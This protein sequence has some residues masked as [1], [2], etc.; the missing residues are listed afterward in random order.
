MSQY[1]SPY[2]P[3]SFVPTAGDAVGPQDPLAG[4]RRAATL[5][6]VVGGLIFLLGSCNTIT[7]FVVSP[8]EIIERQRAMMHGNVGQFQ[9][10]GET[11]R[12]ITII[13][14]AA[15]VMIGVVFVALSVGVRRGGIGSTIAA[16][17]LNGFLILLCGLATL[18]FLLAGFAT[19][20]SGPP[21]FAFACL[22]GLAL[23]AVIW[24]MAWL[25]SAARASSNFAAMQAQ[26]ASQY[27]QYSQNAL[28]QGGYGEQPAAPMPEQKHDS[29]HSDGTFA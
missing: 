25:V 19:G 29:S 13:V 5:M 27:W 6:L 22:T 23:A 28:T 2:S 1:P 7:S 21:F 20:V 17:V 12:A 15:T 18:M 26:Y 9:L 16:M 10:S 4:A 8:Q 3:P 14:G 11:S 24:L